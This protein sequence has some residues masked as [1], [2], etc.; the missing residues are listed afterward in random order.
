M[1]PL[2]E[3]LAALQEFTRRSSHPATQEQQAVIARLRAKVPGPLLDS[4]DRHMARGGRAVA[5]LR[6][7]VCTAC[8]L[9][10]SSCT[11]AALESSHDLET[12]ENCGCVL[13]RESDSAVVAVKDSPRVKAKRISTRR[14][15]PESNDV[16][17]TPGAVETV[18]VPV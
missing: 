15:A 17:R 13:I 5:H 9:R 7:G 2:I 11:R 1:N 10:V 3:T 4:F 6:N 14:A 16:P 8:H 18:L 12:C